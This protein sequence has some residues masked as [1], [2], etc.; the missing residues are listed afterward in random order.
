V[1]SVY[2]SKAQNLI[3]LHP[4]T[5][6]ILV[7]RVQICKRLRSPGIDSASLFNLAGRYG[8][9]D[10]LESIPWNRFLGFLKVYKFG[11]SILFHTGGRIGGLE[12]IP[13][14]LKSL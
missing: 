7:Y 10:S 9:I 2:L 8:G 6:C 13:G 11:L 1:A 4:L 12:S 14:L 5:H 3:P